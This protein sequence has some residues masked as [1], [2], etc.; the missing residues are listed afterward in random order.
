MEK[1][2]DLIKDKKMFSPGNV[3]GVAVSGGSDSMALLHFLVSNKDVFDIDVM[4]IH[5]DHN[6]RENDLR[7]AIFVEDYCKQNRIKFY[8]F[9]VEALTLMKQKGMS[10]EEACREARFSVFENLKKKGLVDKLAI[11][12]HLNDQAETVLLHILRGSGLNGASGMQYIRDDFYVRPFLDITKEEILSYV[13]E[14]QIPFVEDETNVDTKISRNLLRQKI[15]PELRK[16]WTN[17]DENLCNFAKI[18]REDDQ[19]IR[20]LMNFDAVSFEKD[21]A[22]IPLSYF[23]YSQSFVGRLILDCIQKIGNAQ[24]VSK[25]HID[26]ICDFA[27]SGQNGSRIS[28]PN[29]IT[30]FKEYEFITLAVKKPKLEVATEWKFKKGVTRVGD[31]GTI[32]VKKISDRSQKTI[33]G[34]LVDIDKIPQNAV[35][36][37]RREG[38][39]IEK[40]GGGIV[41]LKKYLTDK[42]IPLR[43]R[44]FLPVLCSGMEVLAVANVDI[45]E[46]LK[47]DEKTK[48]IALI[49]FNLKNW[50]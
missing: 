1:V 8:K 2:L 19:T 47:I 24:D 15:L 50:V 42:K 27:R 17:V 26:M 9:K 32:H 33:G 6:T 14:N 41:K 5:V 30:C 45:S 10:M 36:R 34:L 37:F 16:V 12:H 20:S 13:Y 35:W 3:V 38:D 23:S 4:A 46:S 43:L 31:Y 39:F 21:V 40:F 11:A 49:T 28:L 29:N 7:D 18:C 44:D 48:N 25:K 22:K